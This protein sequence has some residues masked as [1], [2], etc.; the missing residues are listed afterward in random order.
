MLVPLS[1]LR[2]SHRN[3]NEW[4]GKVCGERLLELTG[5]SFGDCGGRSLGL[6]LAG[7]LKYF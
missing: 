1:F 4:I 7:V 5:S 6:S 2:N 3:Y